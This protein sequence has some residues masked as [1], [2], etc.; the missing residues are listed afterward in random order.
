MAN[1]LS[2]CVNSRVVVLNNQRHCPCSL[3]E[4]KFLSVTMNNVQLQ[5]SR[6][7]DMPPPL[8]VAQGVA[9]CLDSTNRINGHHLLLYVTASLGKPFWSATVA[10]PRDLNLSTQCPGTLLQ[11]AKSQ[12]SRM[13]HSMEQIST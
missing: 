11:E 3:R 9:E 12:V 5:D 10:T 4:G 13:L 8:M 7:L 1:Q 2:K 6:I